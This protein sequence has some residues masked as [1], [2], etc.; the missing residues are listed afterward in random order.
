[1][2]S[3]CWHFFFINI[4]GSHRKD[5]CLLRPVDLYGGG[6]LICFFI[7]YGS[8]LRHTHV[9]QDQ[10]ASWLR[11]EAKALFCHLKQP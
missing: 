4:V 6:L 7:L 9:P 3:R 5:A 2:L 10:H 1:M 11:R 8:T